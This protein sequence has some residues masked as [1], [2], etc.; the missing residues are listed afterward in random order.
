MTYDSSTD[1]ARNKVTGSFVDFG[2]AWTRGPMGTKWISSSGKYQHPGEEAA[3]T[4]WADALGGQG[5]GNDIVANVM[6]KYNATLA[7][8]AEVVGIAIAKANGLTE[9]QGRMA[10]IEAVLLSEQVVGGQDLLTMISD[11]REAY[12]LQQRMD[13][14]KKKF[15]DDLKNPKVGA[16][17]VDKDR[18]AYLAD[19]KAQDAMMQKT[20]DE[21]VKANGMTP[22]EAQRLIDSGKSQ[23][24]LLADQLGVLRTMPRPLGTRSPPGTAVWWRCTTTDAWW[25]ATARTWRGSATM[26]PSCLPRRWVPSPA[27]SWGSGLRWRTDLRLRHARRRAG[28]EARP[29]HYPPAQEERAIESWAQPLIIF[30]TPLTPDMILSAD[31]TA[32]ALPPSS[33]PCRERRRPR[34][35]RLRNAPGD[36]LRAAPDRRRRRRPGG[37]GV[38]VIRRRKHLQGPLALMERR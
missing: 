35:H 8:Q 10:A 25:K 9:A 29:H 3:Y 4:A 19:L 32:G 30:P 20:K 15:L 23:Q 33:M 17:D 12:A 27:L 31:A 34:D 24:Q 38:R 5:H 36:L 28:R 21:L 11:Y 14:D 13:A 2:D 16:K 1:K 18:A 6:S 26:K 22:E 7:Q 37:A